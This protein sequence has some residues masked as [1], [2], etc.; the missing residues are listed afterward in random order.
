[1]TEGFGVGW[2]RINSC[3]FRCESGEESVPQSPT[4]IL[5]PPVIL[6]FPAVILSAAKNPYL[7]P[8]SFQA[9]PIGEARQYALLDQLLRMSAPHS[10]H[11]SYRRTMFTK[12]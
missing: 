5:S 8:L 11:S 10:S 6:S 9:P 3:E 2:R 1:M 7:N 12:S 4:V